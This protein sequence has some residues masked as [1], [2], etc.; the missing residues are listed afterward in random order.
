MGGF[1]F[2]PPAGFPRTLFVGGRS[3]SRRLRGKEA[4]GCNPLPLATRGAIKRRCDKV[5]SPGE[6]SYPYCWAM[7][8]LTKSIEP[9]NMSSNGFAGF[10]PTTT[11]LPLEIEPAESVLA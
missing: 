2:M 4:S 11:S 10:A 8:M 7:S 3:D 9:S 5:A 6:P 1:G